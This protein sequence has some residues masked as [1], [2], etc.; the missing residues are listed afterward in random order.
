MADFTKVQQAVDRLHEQVEIPCCDVIV[1]QNHRQLYRYMTGVCDREKTTPVSESTKYYM[2]SCTKPVTVVTVMTLIEQGLLHLQDPVQKYLP[3]F[4]QA[5]VER[6]GERVC[7]GKEITIWHLLT[8]TSGLSYNL[9]APGLMAYLEK[10]PQASTYDLAQA[11]VL[12]PLSFSPGEKWQYSVAHDVLGAVV[13]AVSGK[14][15]YEYMKQ[16]VLD[17]IG[18]PHTAFAKKSELPRE[19]CAQ[20]LWW[21]KE[22]GFEYDMKNQYILTDNHQSGGAGLYSTTDDYALFCDM[23]ACGGVAQNGN[24]ILKEETLR[25][26]STPQLNAAQQATFFCST[27][28]GYT[29]GLGVRVRCDGQGH[30]GEFGWDSAAG[31]LA[32]ADPSIGLSI[33]YTQHALHWC[34]L[35]GYIHRPIRDEVYRALGYAQ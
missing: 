1:M 9:R 22:H 7:V 13:E 30:D 23:L 32:F 33:T 19:M 11:F 26:V 3:A 35:D 18:M 2:Y 24:R 25:L 15:F 20:Y 21:G 31:A 14:S 8:M 5:Y 34:D 16:A 6:D 28:P 17:P 4:A 10:H 12:D 29:Y 27:G